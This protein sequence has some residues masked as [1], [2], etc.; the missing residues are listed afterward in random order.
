LDRRKTPILETIIG[1]KKEDRQIIITELCDD[2]DFKKMARGTSD[3]VDL[4]D[5]SRNS[6]RVH[7]RKSANLCKKRPPQNFEPA[8]LYI[9]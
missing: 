8:Y 6:H 5:E 2:K 9:L 1:R 7:T 3:W 4:R